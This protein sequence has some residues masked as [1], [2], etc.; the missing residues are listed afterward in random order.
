LHYVLYCDWSIRRLLLCVKLDVI[1]WYAYGFTIKIFVYTYKGLNLHNYVFT[2][3]KHS[4]SSCIW[5]AYIFKSNEV[6]QSDTRDHRVVQW[7]VAFF[8]CT[9][10]HLTYSLRT[11]CIIYPCSWNKQVFIQIKQVIYSFIKI[12]KNSY[13]ENEINIRSYLRFRFRNLYFWY[14]F[15]HNI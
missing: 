5:L 3:I 10:W 8:E 2:L 14:G 12:S 11:W 9:Q 1:D 15:F 13:I 6:C 4:M 7:T